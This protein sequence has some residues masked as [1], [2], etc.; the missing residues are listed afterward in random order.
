MSS[1]ILELFSQLSTKEKRLVLPKLVFMATTGLSITQQI[2]EECNQ[3]RLHT[4]C[5]YCKSDKIYKRGSKQGNPQYQCRVCLKWF[6]NSTGTPL[7]GLKKTDKLESYLSCMAQGLS[8]DKTCT[9]VGISKQTCFNWRHKILSS[10]AIHEADKLGKTVE[11]DELELAI[12]EKGNKGLQRAARKRGTDF[13]RNDGGKQNITTVQVVTALDREGNKVAR[14]VKS[15]R[16]TGKQLKKA[17]GKKLQKDTL[18]ITDEHPSYKKFQK[19][20]KGIRLKQVKAKEH[21]DKTDAGIHIQKTNNH[22]KQIRQFLD[23]FNGVSSKYLQNYLN[24]MILNKY[25]NS[26][27]PYQEW[28]TEL[29]KNTD[30]YNAYKDYKQNAVLIRP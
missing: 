1:H 24:W 29:M 16:I 26:S 18:L 7:Y 17:I 3:M 27:D 5:P 6:S 21:V 22:H 25:A 4:H 9:I 19:L 28:I 20:Q 14:A 2:K 30:G 23:K 13:K 11:C 15:K 10:L 12:N 8:L